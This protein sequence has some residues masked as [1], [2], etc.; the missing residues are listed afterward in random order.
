MFWSCDT[1]TFGDLNKH[2]YYTFSVI[3]VDLKYSFLA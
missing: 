2:F 1:I 3:E